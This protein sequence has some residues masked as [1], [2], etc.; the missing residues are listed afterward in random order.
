MKNNYYICLN[1]L[2]FLVMV[3]ICLNSC[4]SLKNQHIEHF[5]SFQIGN[6]SSQQVILH[7]YQDGKIMNIYHEIYDQSCLVYLKRE[8]ERKDIHLLQQDTV[9]T[10]NA[11][12]TAL[13]YAKEYCLK[14]CSPGERLYLFYSQKA[15]M[16]DRV[17][18]SVKGRQ[19][20][21]LPIHDKELWETWYDEDQFIYYHFWR[22]E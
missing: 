16:G 20:S 19:D 15:F 17:I 14:W 6:T 22:I 11:G 3:A 18:M 4:F 13:L 8:N 1:L 9:L 7:F 5:E 21:I 10:L 12:Q 2:P